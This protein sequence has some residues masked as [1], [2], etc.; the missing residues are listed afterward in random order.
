MY[1]YSVLNVKLRSRGEQARS[2]ADALEHNREVL[3]ILGRSEE[4]VWE[5][6]MIF[7]FAF[8]FHLDHYILGHCT[9]ECA[10]I[11]YAQSDA[12]TLYIETTRPPGAPSYLDD[13]HHAW[14]ADS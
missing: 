3:T 1:E 6:H 12:A 13:S 10:A 7:N 5:I 11:G 14:R 8:A 4:E 9:F 2:L